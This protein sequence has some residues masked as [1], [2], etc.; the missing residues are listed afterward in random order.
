M[1]LALCDD[2][3]ALLTSLVRVCYQLADSELK[4]LEM[5]QLELE[6]LR[7]QLADYFCEDVTTFQLDECIST[8]NTFIQ[9]FIKAA[10]VRLFTYLLFLASASVLHRFQ[11]TAN[12]TKIR[13]LILTH[14]FS[15]LVWNDLIGISQR[16]IG[17]LTR[18]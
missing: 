5:D 14:I 10:D 12:E 17:R 4:Q 6:Q 18:S 9:Q 7:H 15:G 13:F 16:R 11:D 2:D 1:A 3:L 8:L